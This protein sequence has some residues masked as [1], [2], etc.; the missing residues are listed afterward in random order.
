MVAIIAAAVVAAITQLA[1]SLIFV[2]RFRADKQPGHF[3]SGKVL[4]IS[5]VVHDM[6]DLLVCVHVD[7]SRNGLAPVPLPPE[8]FKHMAPNQKGRMFFPHI[9]NFFQLHNRF[10]SEMVT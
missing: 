1:S 8:F 10:N 2:L 4:S 5:V 9:R 7:V 3:P 6:L